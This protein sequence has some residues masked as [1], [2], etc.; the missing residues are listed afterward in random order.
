MK[1]WKTE[2]IEA[3]KAE[4]EH[5]RIVSLKEIADAQGIRH[6]TRQDTRD[7]MIAVQKAVPGYKAV[8]LEKTPHDSLFQSLCFVES[9]VEFDD[10]EEI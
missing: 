5:A 4:T 8:R 9:G 10:E 7:I 2:I 1:A 3:V 6:I